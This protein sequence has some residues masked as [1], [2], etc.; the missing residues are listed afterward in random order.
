MLLFCDN[1]YLN[2]TWIFSLIIHSINKHYIIQSA[3]EI[4]K[5]FKISV[6]CFSAR[7]SRNAGI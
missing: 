4:V 3:A 6:I 7:V 1:E 5:H 2:T